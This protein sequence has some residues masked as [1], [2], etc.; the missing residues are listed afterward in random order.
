MRLALRMPPQQCHAGQ[1]DARAAA[2]QLLHATHAPIHERTHARTRVHTGAH[3]LRHA[4]A[5]MRT[6]THATHTPSHAGNARTH[7]PSHAGNARTHTPSHACTVAHTNTCTVACMHACAHGH[8]RIAHYGQV[9]FFMLQSTMGGVRQHLRRVVT[10]VLIALC[11]FGE[12]HST[13]K[14][15]APFDAEGPG[16]HS[17]LKGLGP[18]RRW[19]AWAPFDA[20]GLGPIRR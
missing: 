18:I 3:A 15:W 7:T 1:S 5:H 11:P 16:P 20:E 4:H 10:R 19:R 14:G 13:L 17:T 6:C 9:V 8:T 12:P 2:G